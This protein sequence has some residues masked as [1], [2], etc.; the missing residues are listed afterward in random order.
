M[1]PHS[2]PKIQNNYSGR[3]VITAIVIL[4]AFGIGFDKYQDY[5]KNQQIPYKIVKEIKYPNEIYRRYVLVD[6]KAGKDQILKLAEY[7]K[8]EY[9][10][11]YVLMAIFDEQEA[12]DSIDTTNKEYSNS[13]FYKHQLVM[14]KADGS[15]VWVA[16]KRDH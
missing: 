5:K 9:N 4:I 1:L 10:G 11:H 13:K 12:I 2:Q 16:E 7:L 6:E 15:I 8:D 14:M 3:L